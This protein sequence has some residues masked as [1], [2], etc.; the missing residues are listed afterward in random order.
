MGHS[1]CACGYRG[2]SKGYRAHQQQCSLFR[3][4]MRV[5]ALIQQL[6]VVTTPPPYEDDE[7][8]VEAT[9]NTGHEMAHERYNQS[10]DG[11]HEGAA[12]SSFGRDASRRTKDRMTS[13]Q[14]TLEVVTQE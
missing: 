3:A 11:E 14:L 10:E 7:P 12:T 5:S 8:G 2:T 6:P 4:D 13:L 1:E 9:N